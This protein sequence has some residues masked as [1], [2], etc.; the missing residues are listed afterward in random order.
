MKCP[1]LIKVV[2]RW[3]RPPVYSPVECLKEEC[4][5]WDPSLGLC[6]LKTIAGKLD[7]IN[8]VLGHLSFKIPEGRRI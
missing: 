5:W 4:A 2:K 3:F 1:I 6:C 8:T 7:D